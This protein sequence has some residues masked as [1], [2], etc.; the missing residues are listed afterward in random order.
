MDSEA[1][2]LIENIST[3]IKKLREKNIIRTNNLLG[4]LGEFL[5]VEY[6]NNHGDLPNLTLMANSNKHY[7]AESESKVKFSIKTTTGNGTGVIYGLEPKDSGKE[8]TKI[9]DFLV[10]VKMNNDFTINTICE[11]PW[12]VFLEHKKWHK[13]MGAWNIQLTKKVI[14]SSRVLS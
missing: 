14:E 8:S 3:S 6:Y 2:N 1:I 9:F 13:T 7:D 5:A 10:V 11:I 4:D 12:L